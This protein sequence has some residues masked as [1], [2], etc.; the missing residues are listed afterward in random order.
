MRWAPAAR[1][2][3]TAAQHLDAGA[4]GRLLVLAGFFLLVLVALVATK[5]V[6]SGS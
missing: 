3:S 5:L 6:G 1:T 2:V 4:D